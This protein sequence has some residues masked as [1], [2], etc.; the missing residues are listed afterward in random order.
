MRMLLA[1]ALLTAAPASALALNGRPLPALTRIGATRTAPLQRSIVTP[2]SPA[3]TMTLALPAL[4]ALPACSAA[5]FL[6]VAAG[7]A[8]TAVS[9]QLGLQA[10]FDRSEDPVLYKKPGVVSHS[11]IACMFCIFV[12]A[13]G[14][15]TPGRARTPDEQAG[16]QA[17][18][19]ATHT[20]A[21]RLGQ[22]AGSTR[23][24]HSSPRPPRAS[25]PPW[26]PCAGSPS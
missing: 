24:P 8:A 23:P 26:T 1:V 25:S 9:L 16:S 3:G 17:A 11:V 4:S 21:P 19:L 13:I 10:I 18:H 20:L 2:R 5:G 15:G 6:W 14:C 7:G 12:T 22:W